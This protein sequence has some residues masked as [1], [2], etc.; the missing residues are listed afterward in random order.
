[1]NYAVILA[2]IASLQKEVTLLEKRTRPTASGCSND[3][4]QHSSTYFNT[5]IG[6]LYSTRSNNSN[7]HAELERNGISLHND[8]R[9]AYQ[10]DQ[11]RIRKLHGDGYMATGTIPAKP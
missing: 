7:H 11:Y 8:K 6:S 4:S 9:R 1:M 3:N 2:L 10:S 5:L